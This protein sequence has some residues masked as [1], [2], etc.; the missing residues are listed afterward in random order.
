MDAFR[1]GY[2]RVGF[3]S[4]TIASEKDHE[5]R[6]EDDQDFFHG[7][8]ISQLAAFSNPRSRDVNIENAFVLQFAHTPAPFVPYTVAIPRGKEE[9]SPHTLNGHACIDWAPALPPV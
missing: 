8:M 2:M 9:C 4:R 6:Y 1:R 5:K 3:F 7:L